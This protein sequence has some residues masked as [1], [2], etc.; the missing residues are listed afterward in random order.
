MPPAPVGGRMLG[1]GMKS[2]RAGQVAQFPKPQPAPKVPI[3]PSE[4]YGRDQGPPRNRIYP[5]RIPVGQE[6]ALWGD[7]RYGSYPIALPNPALAPLTDQNT[8]QGRYPYA[9]VHDMI[10]N[11]LGNLTSY[12]YSPLPAPDGT[13]PLW[14]TW[15]ECFNNYYTPFDWWVDQVPFTTSRKRFE[16]YRYDNA[17]NPQLVSD[18][19]E[20]KYECCARTVKYNK[21]VNHQLMKDRHCEFQT[22]IG[23]EYCWLHLRQ[24]RYLYLRQSNTFDLGGVV[25][26]E[27]G[28]F[29]KRSKYGEGAVPHI[30]QRLRI[31]DRGDV[32]F[33]Y[34]P[35]EGNPAQPG[36][37]NFEFTHTNSV[38]RKYGSLQGYPSLIQED[39]TFKNNETSGVSSRMSQPNYHLNSSFRQQ[40]QLINRTYRRYID[41]SKRN[42]LASF[43]KRTDDWQKHNIVE[44]T[45]MV[46]KNLTMDKNRHCI[47][48][49]IFCVKPIFE[50][51]ELL[52]YSP[53]PNVDTRD[54]TP[55]IG[56][57]TADVNEWFRSNPRRVRRGT[58]A[59]PDH[60]K[61]F[62]N[63]DNW[64]P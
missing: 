43:I 45:A 26:D 29:A 40:L 53:I 23:R 34:D 15:D 52:F 6:N 59:N 39:L 13:H 32:V 51:D 3:V 35:W 60:D 33:A 12:G 18:D 5:L 58:N 8:Y 24:Y 11:G 41:N 2:N 55:G 16:V 36:E 63:Y 49:V 28:V 61:R 7:V 62:I 50:D 30:P 42:S 48:R 57:K 17:G 20:L 21:S 4:D 25:N 44:V 54:P 56:H 47:A 14:V 22:V 1:G 9:A 64:F 46:Q 37:Q 27:L 31:F 38:K 19:T 10:T